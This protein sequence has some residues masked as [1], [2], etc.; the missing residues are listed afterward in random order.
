MNEFIVHIL[1][2]MGAVALFVY[3][4]KTLSEG[5]QKITGQRVRKALGTHSTW[6][7]ITLLKGVGSATAVQSSSVTTVMIVN[8]VNAGLM[9][10]RHAIW[11]IMGANIGTTSSAWIILI[12]G[13][14]LGDIFQFWFPLLL[15]GVPLLFIKTGF[16]QT[17]GESVVGLAVVFI[18]L[19]FIRDSIE[20]LFLSGD[21][22]AWVPNLEAIQG[23]GSVFMFLALGTVFTVIVHSSA[24]TTAMALV[25][26]GAGLPFE[27]GAA[28]I[29][30]ENLGTTI[31][32]IIAASLGNVHAKRAAR[33][34]LAFNV[35]GAL[36]MV[37][38]FSVVVNMFGYMIEA[39]TTNGMNTTRST[40]FAVCVFHSGFNIAIALFL[41]WFVQIFAR[42]LIRFS[43]S[44]KE[45][46]EEFRLS[47]LF[48]TQQSGDLALLDARKEIVRLATI[49]QEMSGIIM[50]LLSEGDPKKKKKL[51]EKIIRLEDKTD[52]L[53]ISLGEYLSSL[54]Q[55]RLSD[56]GS[57]EVQMMLSIIMDLENQGDIFYQMARTLE[58]EG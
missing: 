28:I 22:D 43:P 49:I 32:A 6:G 2:A 41:A 35:L 15:V 3:G 36:A 48:T 4:M 1:T 56:S 40:Q 54:S 30:G 5:M 50:D 24:T 31:T 9:N 21:F 27:M 34:H 11:G 58:T 53:E 25:L 45:E 52:Q 13:Y 14:S 18:A 38:L 57:L 47:L 46:D 19:F 29:I 26:V 55:N 51:H 44:K 17:W 7:I 39:A 23:V 42:L 16:R 12:L 8:S 10:L 33:A 20:A 37:A